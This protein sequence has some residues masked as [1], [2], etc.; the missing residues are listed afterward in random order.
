ML[1]NLNNARINYQKSGDEVT[2]LTETKNIT[3]NAINDAELII[4]A[5]LNKLDFDNWI[6]KL[7]SR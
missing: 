4:L 6:K 5:K 7:Y 3:G 2:Y 1:N